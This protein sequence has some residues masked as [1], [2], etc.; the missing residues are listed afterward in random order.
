MFDLSIA[1]WAL[2]VF[3]ALLVGFA[4]TGVVG[5]GVIAVPIFAMV[6][7]AGASVGILLPMLCAADII[8]VTYYRQHTRWHLLL[9]LFP[10]VILG[11]VSAD[12]IAS[13]IA[14]DLLQQIIGGIINHT[15]AV[16]ML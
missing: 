8:A 14:D 3:S 4:K 11:I 2:A 7:P 1:F 9:P 5:T 13:Q 15:L 16:Q 10:W 12:F 6:F